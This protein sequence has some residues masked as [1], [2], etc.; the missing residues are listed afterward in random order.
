MTTPFM[1]NSRRISRMYQNNKNAYMRSKKQESES[2]PCC[3]ESNKYVDAFKESVRF[4]YRHEPMSGDC[5]FSQ[6]NKK[7]NGKKKGTTKGKSYACIGGGLNK[8][9]PNT[10]NKVY[11]LKDCITLDFPSFPV[12]KDNSRKPLIP[13][14][15]KSICVVCFYHNS[16]SGKKVFKACR[17][18]SDLCYHCSRLLFTCPICRSPRM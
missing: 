10:S 12:Y 9:N 15:S 3:P 14:P 6:G 2:D 17:H 8:Y 13:D 5:S 16:G 11:A 1:K 4:D 7:K 18:G